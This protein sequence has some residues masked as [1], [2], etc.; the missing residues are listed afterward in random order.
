M[1]ARCSWVDGVIYSVLADALV[2]FHLIFIVFGLLGG[3]LVLWRKWFAF[4]HLPAAIWIAIIEFQGWICPLTPL[5]NEFRK[6]ANEVGYDGGFVEYYVIPIIY[7]SGLT[8]E[9]QFV[10]GCVAI[11]INVLVY[12]FVVY[13]L[14][15]QRVKWKTKVRS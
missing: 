6:L 3:L 13:L 10:L 11:A 4:L 5:E 8:S 15:A 7:P 1:G 2:I 14:V 9:L 12:L